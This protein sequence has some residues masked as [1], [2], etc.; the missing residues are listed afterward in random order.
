[1]VCELH[2]NKGKRAHR[3]LLRL[4][5]AAVFHLLHTWSPH[6]CLTLQFPLRHSNSLILPPTTAQD[7]A[8]GT[9]RDGS[10]RKTQHSIKTGKSQSRFSSKQ[11][12][13]ISGKNTTFLSNYRQ[14]RFQGNVPAVGRILGPQ[15]QLHRGTPGCPHATIIPGWA[16]SGVQGMTLQGGGAGS[17]RGCPVTLGNLLQPWFTEA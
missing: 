11:T 15:C 13:K 5:D 17:S 10:H 7:R 12:A 9:P 14:K 4:P 3:P 6:H 2:L 8:C 16:A 1:M